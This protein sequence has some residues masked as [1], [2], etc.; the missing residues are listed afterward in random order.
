MGISFLHILSQLRKKG[1]NITRPRNR[2]AE[3]ID[4]LDKERKAYENSRI[5]PVCRQQYNGDQNAP[6]VLDCGHG[7]CT[8]CL[9]RLIIPPARPEQHHQ[10]R[11][12]VCRVA[13]YAYPARNRAVFA[14]M[15]GALPIPPRDLE[16]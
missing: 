2:D 12:P 8:S 5:C 16:I 1:I 9:D 3:I 4:Y 14:M 13:V 6:H 11:C 7:V 10:L 15:P